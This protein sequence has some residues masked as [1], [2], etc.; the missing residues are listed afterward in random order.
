MGYLAMQIFLFLLIAGALGLLIGW[1]FGRK[2][3]ASAHAAAERDW[4]AK[5]AESERRGDDLALAGARQDA[6]LRRLRTEVD[7]LEQDRIAFVHIQKERSE[8]RAEIAENK[9]SM[10][11]LMGQVALAEDERRKL[12]NRLTASENARQIYSEELERLRASQNSVPIPEF[13]E[14]KSD[15]RDETV[16]V[17]SAAR[18]SAHADGP[19]DDLK[20]ISGIGP[21][22]EDLLNQLGIFRYEQI[23]DFTPEKI[24]WVNERLMFKG[25]I[26]REGWVEQARILASEILGRDRKFRDRC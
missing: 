21:K 9:D 18:S 4:Q 11:H 2:A 25:R 19:S 3:L 16:V 8:L 13:R 22:I 5:F 1:Y 15:T 26:E 6:E 20:K 17:L 10:Q 23:A 7:E 12:K 14:S 24:S